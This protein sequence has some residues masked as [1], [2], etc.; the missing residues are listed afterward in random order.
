MSRLK[1]CASCMII[2]P[3]RSIHC[4]SCDICVEMF[5][6][7]CP[8]I[9]NCVG[10]RNYVY[11][12]FFINTLWVDV[13]YSIWVAAHD[14]KR[15]RSTFEEEGGLETGHSYRETFKELPLAPLVLLFCSFVLFLMTALILYHYYLSSTYQT[16]YEHSKGTYKRYLWRPFDTKSCWQNFINRVFTKKSKRP[17]F[18]PFDEYNPEVQNYKPSEHRT[19]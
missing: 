5:D 8:F 17:I 11:F 15:R 12:W 4:R 13:V 14:I 16:T 6:H 10:K 3:K 7:H 1:F 9:S 19:P 18:D 2:R